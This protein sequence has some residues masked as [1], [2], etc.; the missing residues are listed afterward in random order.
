M[1]GKSQ[2]KCNGLIP[3]LLNPLDLP[4]VCL[5]CAQC[6]KKAKR[7]IKASLVKP[8][9]LRALPGYEQFTAWDEPPQENAREKE[10]AYCGKLF[11]APP[12]Q[13]YCSRS[14]SKKAYRRRRAERGNHNRVFPMQRCVICGKL[15]FPH[16]DRQQTCGGY[17]TTLWMQR[18]YKRGLP[19]NYPRK[20]S[21]KEELKKELP[22][23]TRANC[24]A[25]HLRE[26]VE[27]IKRHNPAAEVSPSSLDALAALLAAK[28]TWWRSLSRARQ[29]VLLDVAVT[30]GVHGLL[31]MERLLIALRAGKWEQARQALLN[32]RYASMAGRGAVENARQLATGA[33]AAIPAYIPDGDDDDEDEDENEQDGIRFF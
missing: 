30:Y 7:T 3:C 20:I 11:Y 5:S 24:P 32:S 10:C 4:S 6:T 29:A 16:T 31:S 1:G 26:C 28:I 25:H 19:E 17:C 22:V 9:P 27:Q 23:E 8:Q 12:N 2:R 15:F 18:K 33:W 14:C 13:K 21:K